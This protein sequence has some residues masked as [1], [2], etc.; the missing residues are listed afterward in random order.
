MKTHRVLNRL[1]KCAN[2]RYRKNQVFLWFTINVHYR[3]N[4]VFLWFTIN[5]QS[6]L[7]KFSTLFLRYLPRKLA[8]KFN[9]VSCWTLW[10]GDPRNFH[11]SFFVK[12]YYFNLNFFQAL[13]SALL[14][15]ETKNLLKK[16][17]NQLKIAWQFLYRKIYILLENIFGKLSLY[18]YICIT[19]FSR[20]RL[21]K[22]QQHQRSYRYSLVLWTSYFDPK[23]LAID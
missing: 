14:K 2:V 13:Q 6:K 15:N 4:Q 20:G 23:Y 12:N 22:M 5:S 8:T 3:K 9:K 17:A 10:I 1:S 7:K 11:N 16:D 18:C 19:V 21:L